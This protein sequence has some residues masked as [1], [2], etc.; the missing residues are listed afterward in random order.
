MSTDRA[1][2]RP[3]RLWARR[4]SPRFRVVHRGPEPEAAGFPQGGRIAR[5][6]RGL[7]GRLLGVSDVVTGEAVVVEVRFAQVP[8]RAVALFIDVVVQGVLLYAVFA[9]V[10]NV[11]LRA[12]PALFAA[13]SILFSA[14]VIVGYP[15]IFETLS[16]GRSLGK[17]A[18]GLRVV[19]D[20]GGP[21]RFRQALFRALA[22]VPEIWLLAGA[23]ALIT[24]LISERGKRLGDIFAGTVVISERGPRDR[25]L[26]AA[27]PP[28]LAAW[29]TGLELSAL[30]GEVASTAR[31]YLVRFHQLAPQIQHEMGM[32]IAA[33]VATFV[34]PPPP[35]QVPP[36]AYL[37][38]VLAERHR[39][40]GM[41]LARQ[42]SQHAPAPA[43]PAGPPAAPAYTPPPGGHG[44]LVA[45]NGHVSGDPGPTPG[46]FVPPA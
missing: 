8:S 5:P 6:G 40:E 25:S 41:R 11:G 10:G 9:L 36:H 31:Q 20:D 37:S 19:S 16:R 43:P 32:R 44:G 34:S 3:D 2:S 23:P 24:S 33:Q 30:P 17:L 27:M 18:M 7:V 13:L 46:G 35:P 4:P 39:R 29:A 42:Q 12:D 22:A 28:Q 45:G 14:L 38:A 15:V 1:Y 21:E 26:P